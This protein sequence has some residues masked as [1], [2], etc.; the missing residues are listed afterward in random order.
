MTFRSR[1]ARISNAASRSEAFWRSEAVRRAFVSRPEPEYGA[2]AVR[3]HHKAARKQSAAPAL[4]TVSVTFSDEP[5]GQGPAVSIERVDQDAAL[6]VPGAPIRTI[7]FSALPALALAFGVPCR[8]DAQ[9][10]SG[11]TGLNPF[12]ALPALGAVH[13]P[14]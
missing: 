2:C 1:D 13:A 14:R 10:A 9:G 5:A 12:R 7:V 3:S 8:A 11:F 4:D 6:G